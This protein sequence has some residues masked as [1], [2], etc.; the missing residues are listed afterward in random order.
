[1]KEKDFENKM[2]SIQEKIGKDPS[3]L[4]L[5]DIGE[6]LIDNQTVNKEL[7]AKDE[8]ISKLKEEKEKLQ[9]V[10]ASLLQKIPM[11][12]DPDTKEDED[13]KKKQPFDFRTVFDEKR[14]F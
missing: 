13:D 10:N 9:M 14:K 4:I 2:N 11:A 8:E 5:D 6:L 3:A 12:D 7:T 1:M